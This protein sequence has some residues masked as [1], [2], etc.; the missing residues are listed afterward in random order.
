MD[1]YG[2][3]VVGE[4]NLKQKTLFSIVILFIFIIITG[5]CSVKEQINVEE[6]IMKRVPFPKS[7]NI[8]H[9]EDHKG[10]K[11]ILY[12]DKSG[13]RASFYREKDDY[14]QGTSNAELNPHDGFDWTMSNMSGMAIFAG[15]ITDEKITK[16]IVK[17]RTVEH[18]AEIIDINDGKRH[19]FTTFDELEES[20]NG[21]SDPL[22]IYDK[23][24]NLYWKSGVYGDGL[25]E[26]RTN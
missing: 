23:E 14:F 17:Q 11:M 16:V 12:K 7:T 26:G 2:K 1:F 20:L 10:G 22:K 3:V 6:Q 13:F 9:I 5:A 24:G 25:F 15:I 18:Q 8:L 4:V 21:E 19:W